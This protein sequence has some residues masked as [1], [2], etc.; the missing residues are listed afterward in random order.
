MCCHAHPNADQCLSLLGAGDTGVCGRHIRV[1]DSGFGVEQGF[2]DSG[3]GVEQGFRVQPSAGG[4]LILRLTM[5]TPF[6]ASRAISQGAVTRMQARRTPRV[7]LRGKEV[8]R[9]RTTQQ[10]DCFPEWVC[11]LQPATELNNSGHVCCTVV[12]LVLVS[13]KE[14]GRVQCGLL[15]IKWA[16]VCMFD[17]LC[18]CLVDVVISSY[19]SY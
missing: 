11:N 9:G 3:F 10:S 18:I 1:R 7:W 16:R 8:G 2:R 14:G 17:C 6:A 19:S 15:I 5:S 12:W 13:V 4:I